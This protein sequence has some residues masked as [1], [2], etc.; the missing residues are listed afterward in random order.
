MLVEVVKGLPYIPID[1]KINKWE[2]KA[3]DMDEQLEDLDDVGDVSGR[4]THKK[5]SM[6]KS[7]CELKRKI[8]EAKRCVLLL[9]IRC[10]YKIY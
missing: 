9:T 2:D 3:F 8:G 1:R 4:S 7:V 6:R 10:T 5:A